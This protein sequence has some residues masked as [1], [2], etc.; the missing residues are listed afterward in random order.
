MP[1]PFFQHNS[2]HSV[3]CW[4]HEPS[5]RTRNSSIDRSIII[6]ARKSPSSCLQE[7]LEHQQTRLLHPCCDSAGYLSRQFTAHLT[8]YI[9]ES[10]ISQLVIRTGKWN[11]T[12]VHQ[13]LETPA[14]RSTILH[15]STTSTRY[16]RHES[17][18]DNGCCYQPISRPLV[19]AHS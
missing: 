4:L 1:F 9:I 19:V 18:P 15:M 3:W 12:K 7:I 2:L 13:L 8:I 6:L 16:A 11:G 17:K 10:T 14:D 5:T